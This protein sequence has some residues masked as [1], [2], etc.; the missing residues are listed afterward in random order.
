LPARAVR[1]PRLLALAVLIS[2]SRDEVIRCEISSA[3][4]SASRAAALAAVILELHRCAWN[5]WMA[6][7]AHADV[8]EPDGD[9]A[10]PP[11]SRPNRVAELRT[12]TM[13]A[14]AG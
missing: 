9:L 12:V 11:P 13:R 1:S 2:R 8:V 3:A 14:E 6:A 5:R 4:T 10:Y 7:R